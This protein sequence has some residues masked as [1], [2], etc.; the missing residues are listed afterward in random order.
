MTPHNFSLKCDKCGN[1]WTY[2]G[3]GRYYATCSD[4]KKMISIGHLTGVEKMD[5]LK[6]TWNKDTKT[7][8]V[9]NK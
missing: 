8:E 1:E 4:C 2:K 9:S 6:A 7:Y 3:K 5:G